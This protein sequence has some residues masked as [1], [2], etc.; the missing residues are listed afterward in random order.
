MPRFNE[1]K[2]FDEMR[3]L[4]RRHLP[5][6]GQQR[7]IIRMKAVHRKSALLITVRFALGDFLGSLK[8]GQRQRCAAVPPLVFHSRAGGR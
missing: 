4:C 7:P 2:L 5:A 8:V 6:A 1:D 3:T